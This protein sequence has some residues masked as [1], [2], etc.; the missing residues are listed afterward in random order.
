MFFLN[1]WNILSATNQKIDITVKKKMP[2]STIQLYIK[3]EKQEIYKISISLRNEDRYVLLKYLKCIVGI[4]SEYWYNSEEENAQVNRTAVYKK[5]KTRI[6]QNI[7][8]TA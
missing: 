1:I 2:K 3:K 4:R 8:I 6:L 5:R 7:I